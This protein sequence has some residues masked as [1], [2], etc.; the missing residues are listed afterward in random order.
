M[1]LYGHRAGDHAPSAILE[2]VDSP[3][4]LKHAATAMAVGRELASKAISTGLVPTKAILG[5]DKALLAATWR[6]TSVGELEVDEEG[7]P[8]AFS[9]LREGTRQNVNKVLAFRKGEVGS[10]LAEFN[11]LAIQAFDRTLAQHREGNVYV[12]DEDKAA[13]LHEWNVKATP[14]RNQDEA[15]KP[16]VIV[17][18]LRR[19]TRAGEKRTDSIEKDTAWSRAMGEQRV[20]KRRVPLAKRIRLASRPAAQ[21][22]DAL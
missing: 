12:P 16:P 11:E 14:R 6:S 7:L 21:Q 13:R 3:Q 19:P 1:H 10:P 8:R 2:L 20:I 22:S 9:L 17:P 18:T 15:I 5:N 4:D